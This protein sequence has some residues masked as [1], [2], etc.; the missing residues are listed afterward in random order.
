ML[1]FSVLIADF[2]C[3]D[4]RDYTLMTHGKWL[5]EEKLECL[6]RNHYIKNI[7]IEN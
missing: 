7:K 4:L 5:R 3:S 1:D 2:L 6:E